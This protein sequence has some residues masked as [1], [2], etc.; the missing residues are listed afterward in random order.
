MPSVNVSSIPQT[1]V[2]LGRPV[3]RLNFTGP[4]VCV[5]GPGN[6]GVCISAQLHE[7]YDVNRLAELVS[8]AR[9]H[10]PEATQVCVYVP[11]RPEPLVCGRTVQELLNKL[12]G[13][14]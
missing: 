9:Q 1:N 3:V 6:R 5:F 10:L 4:K 12:A 11:G 7:V 14:V 2:D 8:L 13:R